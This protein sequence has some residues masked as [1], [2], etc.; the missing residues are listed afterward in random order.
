MKNQIIG[1]AKSCTDKFGLNKCRIYEVYA[2]SGND[3]LVGNDGIPFKF[4]L[5]SHFETSED[6]DDLLPLSSKH[7]LKMMV[8]NRKGCGLI[9]KYVYKHLN[10]NNCLACEPDLLGFIDSLPE[11][12]N[13]VE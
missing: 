5:S 4:F 7:I 8:K 13:E 10:C 6:K 9:A 2:V 11:D 1:Y 3:I 12:S